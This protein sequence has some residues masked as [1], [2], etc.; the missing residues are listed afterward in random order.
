MP[1]TGAIKTNG[2]LTLADVLHDLGVSPRRIRMKPPPGRA[3]E[4]DLIRIR[5]HDKRLYELVYGMLVEKI[6]GA[7]QACITSILDRR[8]G[9]FVEVN[10][11]GYTM[12]ADGPS[13]LLEGLVRLPDLSY[14][15]W[16]RMPTKEFPA[17]P[18]P[19]V[20]PNL[21]AE[22]LSEGNTRTEMAR[23]LKEY[24]LAGAELVCV[25][26]PHKRTIAVYTAPDQ[27]TTLTEKETLDGGHVLPGFTMPVK[28][29][30]ARLPRDYG[31]R[32]RRKAGRKRDGLAV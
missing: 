28:D 1:Q 24:F 13:R 16:D 15:S 8:V 6:T 29:L 9:D 20:A 18:I 3:T 17:E 32:A 25:I 2:W 11:L 14:V 10:D 4:A 21:A 27:M 30:F 31:R 23:K 12:G 19:G 5:T 22:V 26:D 7:A